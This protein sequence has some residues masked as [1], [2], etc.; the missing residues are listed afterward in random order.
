MEKILK[1][2]EDILSK[3][4]INGKLIVTLFCNSENLSKDSQASV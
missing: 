4:I 2:I 1:E 3:V